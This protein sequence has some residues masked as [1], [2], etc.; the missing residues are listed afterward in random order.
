[1]EAIKGKTIFIGRNPSQGN[2]L[3]AVDDGNKATIGKPGSVAA[4]VSRCKPEEGKAHIKIETDS[5]G[6]LVLTNLKSENVTFVNGKEVVSKR[7]LPADTVELGNDRY[8]INLPVIIE[9]V[10]KLSGLAGAAQKHE[11][12]K[13]SSDSKGGANESGQPSKKFNIVHL[14][15]IWDD[16]EAELEAITQ[17][18]Q[19]L[20]KKRML[21]IMVGSLSGV[22]SPILAAAVALDTLYLTV[23]VAAIS[24][25]LYLVSYRKKDTSYQDRKAATEAFTDSYVCPNPDCNKFLGT[26]S[27]KLLKKQ[28]SMHCPYCKCEFVEK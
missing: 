26:L 3:V 2:L 10:N 22:A 8:K 28:H 23:P 15:K 11:G 20:G 12:E 14:K 6:Y 19:D 18:Q 24:F 1:M 21:P 25:G 4:S 5:S 16:Y 9:T 7:I 13:P 27:Y 17:R